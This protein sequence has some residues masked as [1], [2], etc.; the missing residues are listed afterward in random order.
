MLNSQLQEAY[1]V[2]KQQASELSQARVELASRSAA[3]EQLQQT[4][5]DMEHT[6]AGL[7]TANTELTQKLSLTEQNLSSRLEQCNGLGNRVA[8]LEALW[9][10]MAM[11]RTHAQAAV[12]QL[13]AEK[14]EITARARVDVD[15]VCNCLASSLRICAKNASPMSDLLCMATRTQPDVL[16]ANARVAALDNELVESR[17]AAASLGA[18]LAQLVTD[19]EKRDREIKARRSLLVC[20]SS[21]VG[22]CYICHGRRFPK[23]HI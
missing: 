12:E 7:A 22:E 3:V 19:L 13:Q 10:D 6:L 23:H 21:V 4:V 17:D 14:V 2:S 11:Q 1:A 18:E 5:K 15:K 20:I 16:Q 8:E 9:A